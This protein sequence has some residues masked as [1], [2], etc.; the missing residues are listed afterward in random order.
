MKTSGN[1]V[2]R[3]T[4]ACAHPDKAEDWE[5][6]VRRCAPVVSLVAARVGDLW[7]G[8]VTAAVVNVIVQEV[9]LKLCDRQ[10]R[11]LLD[12]GPQANDSFMGLASASEEWQHRLYPSSKQQGT[13]L[14]A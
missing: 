13:A 7:T 10:R 3:L 1:P 14:A 2:N 12:I 11:F 9:L 5:E 4:K 6:F 8:G